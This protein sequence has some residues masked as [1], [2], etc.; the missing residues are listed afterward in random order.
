MQSHEVFGQLSRLCEFHGRPIRTKETLSQNF[1]DY[2]S[3]N[4][5]QPAFNAIVAER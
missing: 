1:F 3:V 4:I 2:T 5:S